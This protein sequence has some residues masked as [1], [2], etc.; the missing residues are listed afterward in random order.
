MTVQVL[1]LEIV[2]LRNLQGLIVFT[3]KTLAVYGAC[4]SCIPAFAGLGLAP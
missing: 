2:T 4:I 3:I 1:D